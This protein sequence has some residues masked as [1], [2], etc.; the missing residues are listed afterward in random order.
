MYKKL[1]LIVLVSFLFSGCATVPMESADKNEIVKKFNPP[2]NGNAALYIYRSG[3]LGG[4]LK[5]D[6]WVDGECIGETAPNVFFYEE[7]QGDQEHKVSTESEFSPNDLL[8]KTDGGK[9]YFIR[10]YMKLGVFVGGA[11]LELV[12]EAEGKKAVKELDMA[13]KGQCSK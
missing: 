5:K 3:S 2:S 4:A 6:V 10:Q 9:N 7:V 11:G 1:V 12:D 8:L 13:K